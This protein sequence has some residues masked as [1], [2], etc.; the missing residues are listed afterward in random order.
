[1]SSSAVDQILEAFARHGDRHYG[2]RVSQTA[3]ALQ[4]AELAARDGAD[5]AL[6]AASLLHDYGHLLEVDRQL[7]P[8]NPTTDEIHEMLGADALAAHFGPEVVQPIALHVAAKR[9]LC[10]TEP[11]YLDALSAAS[12]LSLALQGGPFDAEQVRQFEAMPFAAAA[13]R[14]RRYDDQGKIEGGETT[15]LSDYRALLERLALGQAV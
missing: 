6:V 7:D 4:C 12:A 9:Y 3:H 15:R 8:D 10:A 1:M 13:V 2:E 5:E 14:L 11:G